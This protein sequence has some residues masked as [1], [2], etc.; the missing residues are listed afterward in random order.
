[1]ELWTPRTASGRSRG[2][3][4]VPRASL[5]Q[6]TPPVAA[7]PTPGLGALET[8]CLPVPA[9][10]TI[11]LSP[12]TAAP[13]HAKLRRARSK[14]RSSSQP[15]LTVDTE[16]VTLRGGDLRRPQVDLSLVQPRVLPAQIADA[17]GVAGVQ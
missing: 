7:A 17:E 11:T 8:A 4:R 15:T 12:E 5:V 6:V 14:E 16:I 10:Q 9:P 3:A 13:L 2:R 1:M